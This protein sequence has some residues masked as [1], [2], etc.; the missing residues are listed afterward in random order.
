M[1]RR[2]A[3]RMSWCVLLALISTLCLSSLSSKIVD[4][5]DCHFNA[6]DLLLNVSVSI[7]FWECK[8]NAS[9]DDFRYEVAS[10]RLAS[11]G[12]SFLGERCL[13]AGTLT[14]NSSRDHS[15]LSLGSRLNI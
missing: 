7:E 6:A 2:T 4:A 10:Q 5:V 1:G 9:C 12:C 3:N 15:L 14:L 13:G 11:F 8:P